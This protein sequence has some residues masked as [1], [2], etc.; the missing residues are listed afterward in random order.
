MLEQEKFTREAA[1][2]FLQKALPFGE[3]L[4]QVS[5]E[6]F[7]TYYESNKKEYAALFEGFSRFDRNEGGNNPLFFQEHLESVAG[8]SRETALRRISR[9][10][11]ER[12]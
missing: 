8:M 5:A 9:G 2:Y 3:G 7:L 12:Q 11:A 10:G 4:L 6:D 1:I